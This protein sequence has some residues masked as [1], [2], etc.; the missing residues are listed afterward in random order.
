MFVGFV[1][2]IQQGVPSFRTLAPRIV[3]RPK[4]MSRFQLFQANLSMQGANELL[5]NMYNMVQQQNLAIS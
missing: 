5:N 1:P 3:Q 4:L 2:Q